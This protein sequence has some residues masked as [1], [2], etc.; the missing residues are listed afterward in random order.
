[1]TVKCPQCESDNQ[2]TAHFCADCGTQLLSDDGLP[3]S[4]TRTLLTPVVELTTGSTFADRYQIIEEIGRGGMGRIYKAYDTEIDEKVAL[5]LIKPEVAADKGTIERFRNEMKFARQVGHRNVSRMFDL[6]KHEGTY[7][8]TMEYVP[9]EDLKSFIRR[10]GQLPVG[11]AV[12][13]AMQVADGLKE[14]HLQGVIHRDLKPRN[15]IID[16]EGNAK[17]MDFGIARSLKS[18][19]MTEK[20]IMVGTPEYMSPEQTETRDVDQRSDIYSLGIL[21]FEMLTGRIPFEG[22]TPLSIA[23]KQ[24]TEKPPRPEE[25]NPRIPDDLSHLILKCMEKDP[26]NRYQSAEEILS[27]LGLIEQELPSTETTAPRRKP[28]TSREITVTVGLKKTVLPI[29]AVVVLVIAA[30]LLRQLFFRYAPPPMAGD[31]PSLAILYFKNN[32]G[33]A[34]LEHWRTALTDLLI[35]D[36]SQ[37]RFVR[38]LS[39]ERLFDVLEDLGQLEATMYSYDTLKE[40]AEKSRVEHVLVG[41]YTEAGGKFRINVSLQDAASGELISSESVEGEGERSFYAM[42]DELTRWIKSNFELGEAILADD[43]DVEVVNITTASPEAYV[44]YSEGRRLHLQGQYQQSISKMQEVLEIDPDF[45]MAHRSLAVSYGNMGRRPGRNR[46]VQKAFELSDRVSE[47]ER[48]AIRGDYYMTSRQTYDRA[49]E[50]YQRLL[51]LYSDDRI[52]NINLGIVYFSIEEFEKA[53]ELYQNYI[54]YNPDGLLGYWNLG[55]TYMAMGNYAAA[56]ETFGQYLKYD[57]D[58]LGVEEKILGVYLFEGD[59]ESARAL[60]QKLLTS[61]PEWQETANLT[62]GHIR[63]LEGNLSAAEEFYSSLQE[64]SRGRKVNLANLYLYRGKFQAALELVQARPV[65]YYDLADLSLR[66]SHPE[67]ALEQYERE[68]RDAVQAQ[69]IWWRIQTLHLQGLSYLKL[70]RFDDVERKAGEIREL[71]DGG[72]NHNLERYHLHLMGMMQ[73]QKGEYIAAIAAMQSAADSLCPPESNF[74]MIHA[75]FWSTLGEAYYHAGNWEAAKTEFEKVMA[76]TVAR[77]SDGDYYTRSFYWLGKIH[78]AQDQKERAIENY[79]RFLELWKD[80]D[81]GLPEV[82]NARTQLASLM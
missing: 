19:G 76:L 4:A 3:L 55:E 31:K 53:V 30:I 51:S 54:Q 9:G 25:F 1:M 58:N 64:G 6:G 69:D 43:P 81:S 68:M 57:Q 56:R 10:I 18:E 23:I 49:I 7:Y 65:Y 63:L 62:S 44:L 47:R 12:S 77:I 67:A 35:T 11:K 59:Y 74:P 38:V 78:Q 82:E 52:A 2:E 61:H 70:G 21:L 79:R 50:S 15:V 73:L 41:N 26:A 66:C 45:A 29:A 48:L 71:L 20:G 42:V 17:I 8:I 80:A 27:A 32:T 13:I 16:R 72:L 36:L 24:K 22:E 75:L 39:A 34:D 14:A 37:S 40:V 60:I 46:A 33:A 28:T 5:K